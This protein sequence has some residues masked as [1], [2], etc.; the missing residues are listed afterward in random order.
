M[1]TP[2]STASHQAEALIPLFR[3]CFYSDYNT[4]LTGN[5]TEPLYTPPQGDEPARIYFTRDYFA[6]ALHEI[7]HWC[8]AGEHRRTLEDYGYWYEPDGRTAE[9]QMLFETVE[10]EPQAIEWIFTLC[11]NRRFRVS[12]DNLNNGMGASDQ[13]KENVYRKAIDYLEHGLPERPQHFARALAHYFRNG[14]H[15]TADELDVTQL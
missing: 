14:R 13:F 15:P 1:S 12:A 4:I 10:V 5:A 3:Q 11:C 6:S 8:I 9:Q 7:A 2:P